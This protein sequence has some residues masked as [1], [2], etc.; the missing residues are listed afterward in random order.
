MLLAA[1]GTRSANAQELDVH[2][3][4]CA[5]L[6][7]SARGWY[8]SFF[9]GDYSIKARTQAPDRVMVPGDTYQ[10][11]YDIVVRCPVNWNCGEVKPHYLTQRAVLG[12][13]RALLDRAVHSNLGSV[14][15][16]RFECGDSRARIATF[17]VPD[18]STL[19]LGVEESVVDVSMGLCPPDSKHHCA[20][21]TIRV[22]NAPTGVWKVAAPKVKMRTP[23]GYYTVGQA[24]PIDVTV[25]NQT[26]FHRY[27][28]PGDVVIR[29]A[30]SGP[31][32]NVAQTGLPTFSNLEAKTLTFDVT[33][34]SPGPVSFFACLVG[35]PATNGFPLPDIC[36]RPTTVQVVA[37]A[38]APAPQGQ[39]QVQFE[40]V[41]TPAIG[42]HNLQPLPGGGQ[43]QRPQFEAVET[44]ALGLI[45]PG[46]AADGRPQAAQGGGAQG[47]NVA[48]P[49]G[50]MV[51]EGGEVR[52][53]LCWCGFGRFPHAIGNNA[54]ECR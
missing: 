11:R 21:H 40:A 2:T 23:T 50:T 16:E 51:C 48:L 43:Q 29:A 26:G 41:E 5:Y 9:R 1:G 25:T 53:P 4:E 28:G 39:P 30:S 35:V 13:D 52:G 37:P 6:K 31:T 47:N 8:D 18:P 14:H 34:Q 15:V 36:G 7:G 44:P 24:I 46:A 49:N 33:S 3:L 17:T 12:A 19:M 22:R 42:A 32:V 54:Y 27:P 38:A 20:G 45:H 10:I